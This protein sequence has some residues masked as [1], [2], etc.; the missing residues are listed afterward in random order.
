M[1]NWNS[2]NIII[3][4]YSDHIVQNR[5]RNQPTSQCIHTYLNIYALHL[6]KINARNTVYACTMQ[7]IFEYLKHIPAWSN[8]KITILLS[9]WLNKKN[10]L[11][12]ITVF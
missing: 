7:G 3:A 9:I 4:L 5:P 6:Y 12:A 11:E 2:Y 1:E 10:S 8:K